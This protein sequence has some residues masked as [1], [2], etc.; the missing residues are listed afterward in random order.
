[1]EAVDGV[2]GDETVVV[3]DAEPLGAYTG[4]ELDGGVGLGGYIIIII[5]INPLL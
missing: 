5:T 3:D 4:I 2:L 1:M